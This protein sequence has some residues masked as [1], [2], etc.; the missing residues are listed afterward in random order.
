MTKAFDITWSARGRGT[1]RLVLEDFGPEP[2]SEEIRKAIWD[3]IA[4]SFANNAHI[5][6]TSPLDATV[7]QIKHA[8]TLAR[9]A[10]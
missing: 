1:V 5:S 6:I 4:E 2:T 10:K 8:A 9:E 3:K 7:R